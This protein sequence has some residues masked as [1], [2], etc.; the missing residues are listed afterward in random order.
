MNVLHNQ[1]GVNLAALGAVGAVGAVA[2][3]EIDCRRSFPFVP[4]CEDVRSL[5]VLEVAV[6]AEDI[7]ELE[8][9]E[10]MDD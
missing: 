10:R 9:A 6:E 1:L 8:R 2:M 5:A 3:R 4:P 7:A